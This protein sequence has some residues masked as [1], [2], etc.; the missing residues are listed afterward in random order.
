MAANGHAL[1]SAS[2]SKRWMA[3]PPS[4]RLTEAMEDSTSDF[5]LEGTD[6]H[7]LCEHKLNV[8]LFDSKEPLEE[9]KY[10]S[11]EME[12]CAEGYKAF[13]LESYEEIKK[14]CKDPLILVEQR[15]DFSNYVPDG[16]GTGDSVIVGEGIIHVIDYKHGMGVLVSS[17]H[18]PQ[19]MLYALGALNLFDDLYNIKKVL[20][21]IYQPRLSNVSTFEMSKD[22]LLKWANEELVPKANMAFKG[23]GSFSCGEWC[24]FCKAKTTCRER[25][26]F[27]MAL[28]AYDFKEPPFLE[29]YEI[30]EILSKVDGLV[31]W[32]NEVKD[33]CLQEALKGKKWDGWKLVE[34]RS[35]RKYSDEE[36]VVNTLTTAGLDPYEKKLLSITELTKKIGKNKF[37][38]LVEK[39]V[40]KPQ[41]KATLVPSTDKR[42]ELIISSAQEDFKNNDNTEEN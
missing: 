41:G 25:A 20:M 10:Y 27:N 9:L 8:A 36:A 32:A 28:A 17:E 14:V 37:A 13:V 38:E 31:N 26:N 23:E 21:T 16:F 19:M 5:A 24:R 30:A 11:E 3:C 7:A 39:Y 15:L 2:A 42:A 29:D 22:D 1:L 34:G 6:A 40:V 35:N 18:N 12:E 4:A 33:Y